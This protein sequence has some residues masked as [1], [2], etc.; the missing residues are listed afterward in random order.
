ML[1]TTQIYY[2]TVLEGRRLKRALLGYHQGIGRT[3]WKKNPFPVLFQ[4]LRATCILWF[5]PPF[6]FQAHNVTFSDLSSQSHYLLLF[7]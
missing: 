6:V 2:L 7:L 1:K 4:L 5:R 3:L